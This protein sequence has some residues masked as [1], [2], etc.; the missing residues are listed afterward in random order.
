MEAEITPPTKEE[1]YQIYSEFNPNNDPIISKEEYDTFV[2]RIFKML[3]A[4]QNLW[5][6][7]IYLLF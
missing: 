4:T 1:K 7:N 3:G 2:D 6:D 5:N